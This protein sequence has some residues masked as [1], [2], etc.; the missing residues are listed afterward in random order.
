[1]RKVWLSSCVE[2]K[3][4]LKTGFEMALRS[5]R[6]QGKV[7]LRGDSDE[8]K[9]GNSAKKAKAGAAKKGFFKR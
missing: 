6:R 9:N 8:N 5:C 1:M 7:Q 3:A 4:L 2:I